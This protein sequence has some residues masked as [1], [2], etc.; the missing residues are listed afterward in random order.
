MS[1]FI[2]GYWD[3]SSLGSQFLQMH[4]KLFQEL[5]PLSYSNM[6]TPILVTCRKGSRLV[7][8]DYFKKIAQP[9][10]FQHHF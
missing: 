8:G 3:M 6:S 9:F 4:L 2:G 7:L 1:I 10:F 5:L